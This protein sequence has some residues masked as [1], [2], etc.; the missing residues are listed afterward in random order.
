MSRIAVFYHCLFCMGD[1]PELVPHGLNVIHSQMQLIDESG[2]VDT[3]DEFHVGINGGKE[4]EIYADSVIPSKAVKIYHGLQCH[5]E[6]RTI[7]HMQHTM[8]DR[9]GWKVL[10]FH[11]KG[12][13]HDPDNK[14]IHRWRDCMMHHLVTNWLICVNSLNGGFDSAGCHWKTGQVNGHQ[15][16]WAGNFWWMKSEFLNTLPPIE[17]CPRLPHMG[18]I[19]S[20][21]SRYEGEVLIGEGPRLPKVRDYHPGGPFTCPAY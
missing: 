9:P 3:C 14:M 15:S 8:R 18:G 11:A 12:F 7:M 20:A 4:S 17:T 13:R 6:L 2:L 19:D 5:N 10:Y 16:L 21:D 1:P